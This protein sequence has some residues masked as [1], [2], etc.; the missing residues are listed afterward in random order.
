MTA[1]V[2]PGF[3]VQPVVPK[4]VETQSHALDEGC[5]GRNHDVSRICPAQCV[6]LEGRAYLPALRHPATAGLL[7]TL[8]DPVLP[9]RPEV[10]EHHIR[11]FLQLNESA[12]AGL[13]VKVLVGSQGRCA[14]VVTPVAT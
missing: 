5:A 10:L 7:S 14:P 6:V 12:W 11:C 3:A 9:F 1:P 4:T 2:L 13:Q 8:G